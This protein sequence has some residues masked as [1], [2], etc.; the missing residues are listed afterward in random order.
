MKFLQCTSDPCTYTRDGIDGVL[1]I[2]VYVDDIIIG[3]KNESTINEVKRSL[4]KEFDVTD[5]GLLHYFLGIKI[6]QN[7]K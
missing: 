7:W 3:G 1:L 4:S 2:A 6:V 5:M